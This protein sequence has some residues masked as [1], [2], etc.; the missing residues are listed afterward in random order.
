[1]Y[2]VHIRGVWSCWCCL[3][4]L[5]AFMI[6]CT[7]ALPFP[8]LAALPLI[9]FVL[10]FPKLPTFVNAYINTHD[11]MRQ[12]I[13]AQSINAV[14]VVLVLQPATSSVPSLARA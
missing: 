1:M 3:Y 7:S 5:D 12:P 8:C 14:H 11:V 13:A 10:F 2:E 9:H 6:S 4:P